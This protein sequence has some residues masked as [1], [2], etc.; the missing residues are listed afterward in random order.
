MLKAIHAQASPGGR[1]RPNA[2]CDHSVSSTY[3]N[4]SRCMIEFAKGFWA[5]NCW[6][7]GS[8]LLD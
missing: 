1:N 3:L 4:R 6:F 8:D 2:T 7:I 5:L